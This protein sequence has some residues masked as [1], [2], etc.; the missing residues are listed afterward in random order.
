MLSMAVS[1][2]FRTTLVF[3]HGCSSLRLVLFRIAENIDFLR[4][5]TCIPTLVLVLAPVRSRRGNEC[6]RTSVIVFSCRQCKL[7]WNSKLLFLSD[8]VWLS[9]LFTSS[10]ETNKLFF[11]PGQP[12]G[13]D[14]ASSRVSLPFKQP[15]YSA[16]PAKHPLHCLSHLI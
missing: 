16:S 9:W 14:L 5:V 3:I 4:S 7:L 8:H 15:T 12:Y 10:Q 6:K 1:K 2:G 13:K 11:S